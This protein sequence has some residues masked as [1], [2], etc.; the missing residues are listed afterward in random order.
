MDLP[1]LTRL[2][3]PADPDQREERFVPLVT[4]CCWNRSSPTAGPARR[5][6]GTT[7]HGRNG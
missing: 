3:P 1:S 5:A 7:S 6:S 2:L 4:G